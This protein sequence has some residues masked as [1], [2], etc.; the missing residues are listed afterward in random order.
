MSKGQLLRYKAIL[1][2]T[3]APLRTKLAESDRFAGIYNTLKK[4][5]YK[6]KK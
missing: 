1:L 5:L 3:L 2:L 4:S 6:G